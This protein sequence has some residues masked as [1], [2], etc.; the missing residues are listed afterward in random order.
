MAEWL[1]EAGIGESRAALVEDG[2]ILKARIELPGLR[3]GTVADGRLRADNRVELD[4]GGEV[5][6]DRAPPGITQGG[7]LRVEIVREAIPEP[8][9][10]KLAKAV[11]SDLPPGP[12]PDLAARI[13]ASGLPVHGPRP[14]EADALEAAGWSEVL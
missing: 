4:Q 2:R 7:R 5:L 13:V 10:A 6:L 8:G 1:Y 9:R 12:G 3:A 11:A 14:H